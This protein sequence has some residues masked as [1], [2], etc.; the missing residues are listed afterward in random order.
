MAQYKLFYNNNSNNVF[1][2][3]VNNE[4]NELEEKYNNDEFL[5]NYAKYN[6]N[7]DSLYKNVSNEDEKSSSS[8]KNDANMVEISF[9][10]FYD[11]I[12]TMDLMGPPGLPGPPGPRGLP[13]VK[14]EAGEPGKDGNTLNQKNLL[15]GVKKI[16]E[17]EWDIVDFRIGVNKN[18]TEDN[19][20]F[21][22]F[23]LPPN[24][25]DINIRNQINYIE[26]KKVQRFGN[27]NNKRDI[28]FFPLD[29][30]P[31]GN[32]IP[33]KTKNGTVYKGIKINNFVWNI[34]Q[35]IESNEYKGYQYTNDLEILAVVP[36]KKIFVY[37]SA[38]FQ[39]NIEIH[40][41]VLLK[42][43]AEINILP[44][45][46][47]GVNE[48]NGANTCLFKVESFK[49]ETLQGIKDD[50]ITI[51]FPENLNISSGIISI[52]VSLPNENIETLKGYDKNYNV[53]YGFIP[54]NQ[55]LVKFDY[56]LI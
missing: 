51:D 44:Y 39:I 54:I 31:S 4:E 52:R 10:Q 15:Y 35:S 5:S 48:K 22:S 30:V 16:I 40:S 32:I 2:K 43:D 42:S 29:Y 19:I 45:Q 6:K 36:Q 25:M 18:H 13:G 1:L 9:Q 34:I 11:K 49:I 8:K 37:E 12:K 27:K 20:M 23:Y 56:E 17:S 28:H 21:D 41:Q 7:L 47:K 24:I 3:K 50:E 33:F 46:N 38:K 14:G 53:S 55:F 26:D